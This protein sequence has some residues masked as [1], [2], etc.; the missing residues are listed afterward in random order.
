VLLTTFTHPLVYTHNGGD[1]LE[2]KGGGEEQWHD[3]ERNVADVS[4]FFPCSD[5]FQATFT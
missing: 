1:T 4:E 3:L 5:M 2:K